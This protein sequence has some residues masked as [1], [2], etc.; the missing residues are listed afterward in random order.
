[1]LEISM[2][3]AKTEYVFPSCFMSKMASMMWCASY[4]V[5]VDFL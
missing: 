2:L 3:L 4:M 1:M 5:S